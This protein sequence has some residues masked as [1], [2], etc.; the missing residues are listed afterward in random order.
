[1]KV[2]VIFG[3]AGEK[4]FGRAQHKILTSARRSRN[5][6]EFNRHPAHIA[7]QIRSRCSLGISVREA[8]PGLVGL[9]RQ[10]CSKHSAA[11]FFG[12]LGIVD[13]KEGLNAAVSFRMSISAHESVRL[14]M[15]GEDF[16][17]DLGDVQSL[18]DLGDSPNF[19][20]LGRGRLQS[21]AV[22]VFFS[23]CG[24]GVCVGVWLLDRTDLASA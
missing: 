4:L 18:V 2:V 20:Q 14:G 7:V 17:G 10:L 23:L 15:L 11:V 16:F 12:Q 5:I 24:H 22:F 13:L 9:C 1:M 21:Q 3:I 6:H 19:T 8:D